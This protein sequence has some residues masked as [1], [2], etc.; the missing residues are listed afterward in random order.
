MAVA[1]S[2]IATGLFHVSGSD[3]ESQ[4]LL[5]QVLPDKVL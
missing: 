3:P 5:G 2:L 4:S 1:A